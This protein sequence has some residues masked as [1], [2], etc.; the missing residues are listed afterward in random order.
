MHFDP[1]DWRPD[2]DPQRRQTIWLV[3]IIAAEVALGIILYF[4]LG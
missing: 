4:A 2:D 1:M 3:G